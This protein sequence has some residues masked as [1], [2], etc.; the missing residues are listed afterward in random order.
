MDVQL[1]LLGRSWELRAGWQSLRLSMAPLLW[2]RCSKWVPPLQV[3]S[4][5][6]LP[7]GWDP[8]QCLT[9]PQP[10]CG[11]YCFTCGAYSLPTASAVVQTALPLAQRCFK[12]VVCCS[13]VVQTAPP[14]ASRVLCDA[15]AMLHTASAVVGTAS[16]VVQTASAVVSTAS[17]VVRTASPNTSQAHS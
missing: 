13:A 7:L 11:A 16:A 10:P 15:S 1:P 12:S 5:S 9:K 3:S 6:F 14:L 8:H 2:T 17:A 4:A